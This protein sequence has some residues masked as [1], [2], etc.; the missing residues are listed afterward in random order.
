MR[1]FSGKDHIP[2]G[3]ADLGIHFVQVHR[4]SRHYFAIDIDH[5]AQRAG[6]FTVAGRLDF[7]HFADVING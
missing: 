5:G 4:A 3:V 7:P 2:L 1:G 6:A